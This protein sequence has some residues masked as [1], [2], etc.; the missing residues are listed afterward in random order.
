MMNLNNCPGAKI[1]SF[2]IVLEKMELQD[3]QILHHFFFY[4]RREI[5]TYSQLKK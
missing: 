2:L 5:C 1:I 3:N 4:R